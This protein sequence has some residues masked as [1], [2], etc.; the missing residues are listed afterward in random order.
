MAAMQS[1]A[2]ENAL[3]S[4]AESVLEKYSAEFAGTAFCY[5]NLAE[6]GLLANST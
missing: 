1:L 2:A 4:Y 5:S 6:P 3:S